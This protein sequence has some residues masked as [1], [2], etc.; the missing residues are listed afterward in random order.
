MMLKGRV[1]IVT[2]AGRGIGRGIALALAREGARVAINYRRDQAAAE[3]TVA[4]IKALG[5]QAL[6]FP[7]DVTDYPK[8]KEMVARVVGEWGKLDILVNNAGIA[9]RG[10]NVAETDV[11]EMERVLRVHFFGAFQSTQAVLPVMRKQPRG[12]IIFISSRSPHD[13]PPGHAPYACAKA[14]LETLARVLA[15]EEMPHG[16]RVNIIALGLVETDMG[17]RLLKGTRGLD[18]PEAAPMMP[19]G[20]VCQPEDVGNLAAFLC[21]DEAS[22][23]SGHVIFLDGGGGSEYIRKAYP[24]E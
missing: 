7:A 8:V 15:K 14:A 19:F 16:I 6:A 21:S 11:A 5:T 20:R 12:D 3:K 9:S 23:I 10:L 22:Y 13:A 18:I 24:G 1:A 2:G 17:R 4:E